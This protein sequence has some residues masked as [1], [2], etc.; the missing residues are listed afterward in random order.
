MSRPT[1]APERPAWM[2]RL[3]ALTADYGMFGALLALCLF[4]TIATYHSETPS[5]KEGGEALAAEIASSAKSLSRQTR[6]I[7]VSQADEKEMEFANAVRLGLMA[8]G[9]TNV[10]GVSGDP[11]AV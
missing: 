11:P 10:A 1:G 2:K 6:I 5:G 8:Q 9:F 4:F 3:A 7:V